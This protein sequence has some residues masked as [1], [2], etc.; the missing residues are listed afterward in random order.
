L[1][2]WKFAKHYVD[3]A[4]NSVIELI[5]GW[6]QLYNKE[7]AKYKLEITKKTVYVK[8]TLFRIAKGKIKITIE[9]RKRYL[10]IDLAKFDYLLK[11]CNSTG[12]LIL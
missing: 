5:K 3:S 1:R 12:G 6:I 7:K 10:E 2:N 4:I 11:D 8:T 9:S